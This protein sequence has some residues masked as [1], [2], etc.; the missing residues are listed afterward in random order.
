ME[1]PK[2]QLSLKQIL[3]RFK[4]GGGNMSPDL[5]WQLILG[6]GVVGIAIIMTFAYLTYDWATTIDVAHAPAQ[7]VRDTLSVTEL[8]GVITEYKNKE[9]DY[10]RLLRTPPH[11]PSFRKGHAMTGAPSTMSS[12]TPAQASTSSSPR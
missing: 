1:T 9:A 8:E 6:S 12:S 7:K 5:L 3:H 10:E 4:F 2:L 11:A